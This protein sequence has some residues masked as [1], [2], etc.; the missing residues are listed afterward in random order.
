MVIWP[1]SRPVMKDRFDGIATAGGVDTGEY[2]RVKPPLKLFRKVG[3]KTC[4]S[5]NETTWLRL[6]LICVKFVSALG[7]I[8]LPSEIR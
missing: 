7:S 2:A 1:G 8:L 5:C 4:V 6:V 3:E